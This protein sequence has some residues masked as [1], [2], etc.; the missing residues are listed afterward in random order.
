MRQVILTVKLVV[1]DDADMDEVVSEMDYEFNHEMIQD[2]EVLE[3][4]DDTLS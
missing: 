2:T 1:N 4:Y 3:F